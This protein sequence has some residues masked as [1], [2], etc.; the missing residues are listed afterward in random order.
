MAEDEVRYSCRTGRKHGDT[1]TVRQQKTGTLVEVPC[2]AELRQA[3]DAAMTFTKGT[4]I[5]AGR[6]GRRLSGSAWRSAF[7]IIR[8]KAGLDHLQARDL[9]RTAAVN[10]ARADATVPQIAAITGHCITRTQ[11][12]LETTCLP[13]GVHMARAA[14]IK[15]ERRQ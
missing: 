11:A 15:L 8:R 12:I 9:R 7:N 4:V 6:D 5:V 1:L 2:I 14:I 10:L 3:R 13:S